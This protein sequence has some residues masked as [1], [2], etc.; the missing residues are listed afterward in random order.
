LYGSDHLMARQTVQIK[1]PILG[2]DRA[3]AFQSGPEYTLCDAANVR[4]RSNFDGRA[5]LASRPGLVKAFCQKLGGGTVESFG[6]FDLAP[7][8]DTHIGGDISPIDPN[9][10]STITLILGRESVLQLPGYA[11]NRVLFHFDLTAIPAGATITLANL[12]LTRSSNTGTPAAKV[13]RIG[14]TGGGATPAWTELGVNWAKYDGTTNWATAGGDF[15]LTTP[16]PADW[17]V[18]ANPTET[19]NV[20]GH[21]QD[22]YTNRSKHLHMLLKLA[23]DITSN[24]EVGYYYSQDYNSVP[25]RR[26]KLTYAYEVTS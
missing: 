26:P 14:T 16:P 19:I 7:S 23:N 20:L 3:W 12:I 25:T 6:P 17:S 22:A 4:G 10:G 8:K 5:I 13:H 11:P 1:Q 18:D 24:I 21:A 9:F 2:L 15:D